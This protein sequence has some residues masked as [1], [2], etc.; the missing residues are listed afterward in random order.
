M[1]INQW[2]EQYRPRE[3]L[4]HQGA[5]SLS[6]SE[7]IAIFLRTGVAGCSAIDLSQRLLT[8]YGGIGGLLD[9]SQ[10]Q[11]L[12]IKGVGAA[13]YV[14]LQAALELACRYLWQQSKAQVALDGPSST[15]RFLLTQFARYSHEVF[16]CIWLD[17]H[18]V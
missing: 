15:R 10:Q 14:Q 2:P 5:K 6:D 18:L 12:N 4:M 16:A 13:K 9:L 1:G 11:F 17:N 7:L 3:K 8:E